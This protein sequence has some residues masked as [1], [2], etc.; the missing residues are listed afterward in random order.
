VTRLWADEPL[1]FPLHA[2]PY[3]PAER[4]PKGKQAP[5]FPT[6]PH[7][8]MARVDAALARGLPFRAVVGDCTDGESPA[9]EGV[10]AEA[11]LP[12]VLGLKPSH[13]TGAAE[14]DPPTPKEA[15]QALPWIGP[16]DP[17]EWGAVERRFRDGHTETG[18]AAFPDPGP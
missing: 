11:G 8:G 17:G 9:F 4:L 2:E 13:G 14:E 15:A 10:L 12:S 5:A 7:I 1:S 16:E 3:E 18:W 6:Q